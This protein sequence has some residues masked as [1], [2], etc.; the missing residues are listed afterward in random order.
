MNQSTECKTTQSI[1]PQALEPPRRP[2]LI[3]AALGLLLSAMTGWAQLVP[4]EFNTNSP[5]DRVVSIGQSTTLNVVLVT[6]QPPYQWQWYH[7]LTPLEHGTNQSLVF[8]NVQLSDLGTYFVVLT[9]ASTL[10]TTSRVA[11]LTA[12]FNKITTGAVVTNRANYMAASWADYDE[13]GFIDLFVPAGAE[14]PG[15]VPALYR[16]LAGTAFQQLTAGEVGEVVGPRPYCG[17][18]LWADFNN[19]GHLDLL[20]IGWAQDAWTAHNRLFLGRPDHTFDWFHGEGVNPPVVGSWVCSLLDYDIDGVVDVYH[21][22]GWRRSYNTRDLLYR[23]RGDGNFTA[24]WS[25]TGDLFD[26]QIPTWS[27][28]DNDGDLDLWVGGLNA[29]GGQFYRNLGNGAF[30]DDLDGVTVPRSP[31]FGG[32]CGD[33]DNDGFQD[34]LIVNMSGTSTLF[35]NDQRGSFTNARVNMQGF[36]RWGDYDNDGD[37]DLVT[38][39]WSQTPCKFYRNDGAGAFRLV[40]LGYPSS[41]VPSNESIPSWADYNN[42][43][44]LD[45]FVST[46]GGASF[47][48]QSTGRLGGNSNH[49]LIVK[50]KGTTSNRSAIGAKVRVRAT[51][52]GTD[53][54]QLREILGGW[55]DPLSAHFGLGD[56][57]QVVTLRIEWPSGIV[58]DIADVAVDQILTVTEPPRLT[59]LGPTSFRIACWKGQSV[60]VQDSTDLIHWEPLVQLTNVS[61]ELAYADP[62]MATSPRRFYR[63]VAK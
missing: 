30:S 29:E 49:W 10:S 34:M 19:D 63:V 58:Q 4:P 47:L 27:D 20:E 23:G 28:F 50:P 31:G 11:T 38:G 9:D 60:E 40:N 61:G 41:D 24:V 45:L 36:G 26:S 3:L 55:Y 52:R 25:P 33:Y 44:F 16:N 42:D 13:D 48:Y 54:W 5:I 6:A 62:A 12:P 37:L 2:V 18:G 53:T 59:V 51:I 56:A 43:G 1:G 17:L 35:H 32:V 7:A 14:V 21:T 57:T 8:S 46:R 15:Q 39:W 22:T